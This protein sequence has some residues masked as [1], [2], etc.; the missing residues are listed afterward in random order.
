LRSRLQLFDIRL[1]RLF[2][3]PNS[4]Y[5]LFYR[6]LKP[7]VAVNI[8]CRSKLTRLAKPRD[9]SDRKAAKA[10]PSHPVI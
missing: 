8:L 1:R 2:W 5:S 9:L 3:R 6:H 10:S 4:L 7:P